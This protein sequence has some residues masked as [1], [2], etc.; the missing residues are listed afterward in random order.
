MTCYVGG[1]LSGRLS[2]RWYHLPPFRI[3]KREEK[4]GGGATPKDFLLY[5]NKMERT[6]TPAEIAE[7]L[8][9]LERMKQSHR[10]SQHRYYE[11][12]ANA[13]KEYAAAHYRRKKAEREAAAAVSG[14]PA[15]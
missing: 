4:G 11:R 10:E 12:N 8:A 13:K 1:R 9:T 14:S 3:K 7:A 15:V 5:M 2:G 6:Y